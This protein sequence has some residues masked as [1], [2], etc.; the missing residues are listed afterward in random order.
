MINIYK[1]KTQQLETE[2]NLL[3]NTLEVIENENKLSI[4]NKNNEIESLKKSIEESNKKIQLNEKTFR[5]KLYETMK[6]E[7]K[8]NKIQIMLKESK[9]QFEKEL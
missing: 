3:K 8:N 5:Q 7:D 6:S 9:I 2:L 1:D 4:E